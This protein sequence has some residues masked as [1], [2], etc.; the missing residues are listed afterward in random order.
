M[1]RRSFAAIAEAAKEVKR[2]RAAHERQEAE[3]A[4]LGRL[5]ALARRA[6]QVWREIPPL[7]AQRTARGYDQAVEHLAELRDLAAHR[8]ER[9]AFDA[10]LADVV[11]PYITSAALQRRL[12][13]KRLV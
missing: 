7:F 11:A 3:R 6:E 1:P 5:E 10:R 8:N 9:A 4:R 12:K 2:Q 13:E